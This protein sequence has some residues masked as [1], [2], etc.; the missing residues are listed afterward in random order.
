MLLESGDFIIIKKGSIIYSTRSKQC[1]TTSV[2]DKKA[3]FSRVCPD[4]KNLAW[5]SYGSY[6][7]WTRIENLKDIIKQNK[8]CQCGKPCYCNG[9]C[10]TCYN[11]LYRTNYIELNRE[12]LNTE[13]RVRGKIDRANARLQVLTHYSNGTPKCICCGES[14]YEF[15]TIDH[16][17]GKGAKHRREIGIG[18]GVIYYWLI[19][20]NFPDGFQVLC[21]N[22]NVC[23]GFYNKCVHKD[24]GSEDMFRG[25]NKYEAKLR[26]RIKIEVFTHYS[27]GIPKCACCGEDNIYFLAIDH[28][29]GNGKIL[30]AIKDLYKGRIYYWL[31]NNNYPEGFRVLCYNCNSS[32]GINKYC[33]H[34]PTSEIPIPIII[35]EEDTYNKVDENIFA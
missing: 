23:K 7:C 32:L 21:Y 4:N 35:K 14:H 8:Y 27:Q 24:A 18:G 3:K 9:L 31:K 20:N 29:D 33:P 12:K 30:R 17:N 11:K 15:L 26:L 13:N 19:K 10:Q 16:K 1:E 34:K 28:I 2:H 22:C 5:K 25:K 6:W